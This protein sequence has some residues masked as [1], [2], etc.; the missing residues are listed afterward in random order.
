MPAVKTNFLA[1]MLVIL[2]VTFVS[3]QKSHNLASSAQKPWSISLYYFGYRYGGPV[4][5]IKDAMRT[6]EFDETSPPSWFGPGRGHP[7]QRGG[8]L[9]Y[10]VNLKYL[11]YYP[12]SA[13]IIAGRTDYG[14][15]SG[16]HTDARYLVIKC[17]ASTVAPNISVNLRG[18][19]FR[20][21]IGPSLYF[22]SAQ[23]TTG[24][25]GDSDEKYSTT[26]FGFIAD[27]GLRF[28]GESRFFI[29][30]LHQYQW[31]GKADLGPFSAR[32]IDNS[33]E[34]PRTEVNYSHFLVGIGAGIR[35]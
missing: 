17:S 33:A 8:H 20:L 28:P 27:L 19:E 13:G 35:F 29:E 6:A 25:Y 11:I 4:E 34:L 26:K 24:G 18:D 21:A 2:S 9:T 32:F 10:G 15:V 23:K 14:E 12:I 22:T 31:V 1:V 30:L 7:H 16:Y 5:K 3:A